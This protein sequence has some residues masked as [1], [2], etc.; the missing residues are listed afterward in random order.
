[1]NRVHPSEAQGPGTAPRPGPNWRQVVFSRTDLA[2]LGLISVMVGLLYVLFHIQ[3]NSIA[4]YAYTTSA[5]RWMVDFWM[6]KAMFQ[7][8]DYSHGFLIP[9]VSA[10]AIW[11][12]RRALVRAPKRTAWLGLATI[13]LALLMHWV[14]A[15]TQQTRLS[16][17]ALILLLWGIPWYLGGW[18]VAR[19]LIFPLA[20]LIFC[21]PL[22][23]LDSLT[24]PLRMMAVSVSTTLLN[25]IGIAA[26]RNGSAIFSSAA[27]GFNF[28]V[29]D[30]CS[31]IR[32]LLA[33]TALTA[34]YAYWTQRTLV[35]QWLLFLSSIPLAILGNVA[36]VVTIAVVAEAF[37]E[38]IALKIYHDYSGYIFFSLNIVVM[39]AIGQLLQLNYREAWRTWKTAHTHRP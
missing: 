28:D 35:K 25:G 16:L 1:M 32:S 4:V 7:G 31:G 2:Y 5:F 23:F 19:L 9:V 8:V 3:G 24:F 22:N 12:R 33:M 6:S 10:V 17:M 38:K 30:P 39:I 29:A 18:Q 15:K 27:G 34:A 14:G 21:I 26:W 13:V 11:Q 37:G 20:Y 36:R